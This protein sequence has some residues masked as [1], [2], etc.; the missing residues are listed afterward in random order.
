MGPIGPTAHLEINETFMIFYDFDDS[1][2]TKS[3]VCKETTEI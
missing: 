1:H 2:K 3:F